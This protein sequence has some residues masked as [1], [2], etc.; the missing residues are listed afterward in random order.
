MQI[1]FLA[2]IDQNI[3]I[4]SYMEPILPKNPINVIFLHIFTP[5]QNFELLVPV[6]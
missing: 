6:G 4:Y 2:K 3:F 5:L 1:F